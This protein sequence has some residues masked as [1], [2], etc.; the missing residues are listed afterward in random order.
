[1]RLSHKFL[2]ILCLSGTA[3]SLPASAQVMVPALS[4]VWFR[5]DG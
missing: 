4:A 5:Y 1:M 2:I 3:L